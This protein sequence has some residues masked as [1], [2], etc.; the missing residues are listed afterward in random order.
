VR[1]HFL[2]HSACSYFVIPNIYSV[3]QDEQEQLRAL[4]IN[5]LAGV[6][7]NLGLIRPL[8]ESELKKFGRE[9]TRPSVTDL[10]ALEQRHFRAMAAAETSQIPWRNWLPTTFTDLN[11]KDVPRQHGLLSKAQRTLDIAGWSAPAQNDVEIFRLVD[12]DGLTPLL[13]LFNEATLA[14]GAEAIEE[15]R[16]EQERL[17]VERRLQI[18]DQR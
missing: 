16:K 7:A 11:K 14:K 5:Q 15:V 17:A 2:H 10:K 8:S 3:D 9:E 12:C 18:A 13:A 6:L 4:A 1:R